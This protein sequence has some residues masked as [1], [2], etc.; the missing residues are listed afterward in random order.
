MVMMILGLD[1]IYIQIEMQH[2][3]IHYINSKAVIFNYGSTESIYSNIIGYW[4]LTEKY[5]PLGLKP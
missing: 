5:L 1:K 2:I 4:T 3:I